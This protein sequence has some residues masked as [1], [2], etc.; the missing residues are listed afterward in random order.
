MVFKKWAREVGVNIGTKKI[1]LTKP[2]FGGPLVSQVIFFKEI[3]AC[4]GTKGCIAYTM[5][6][7]GGEEYIWINVGFL[8]SIVEFF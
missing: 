7:P 5:C 1:E 3:I 6:F 2:G 4:C 8:G